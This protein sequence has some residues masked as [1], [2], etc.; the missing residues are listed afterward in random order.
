MSAAAS[1]QAKGMV[2]LV[3]EQRSS[4]RHTAGST[5]AV[6]DGGA[7]R[8]AGAGGSALANA[9]GATSGIEMDRTDSAAA[10]KHAQPTQG[11]KRRK[12]DHF[13]SGPSD[14][15]LRKHTQAGATTCDGAAAET[16]A[17]AAGGSGDTVATT[18]SSPASEN[19]QSSS[20]ER[21]LF[22][23]KHS[24]G[25][26]GADKGTVEVHETLCTK[27]QARCSV[28]TRILHLRMLLDHTPARLK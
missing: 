10:V 19:V 18:T 8:I 11:R 23:C 17:A 7:A 27:I 24:C 6:A 1:F 13:V 16:A 22:E 25:L 9:P 14:A 20:P 3:T 5:V 2:D 15:E 21:A 26:E 28:V 4:R 12:T